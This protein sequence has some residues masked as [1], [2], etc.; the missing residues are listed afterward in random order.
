MH[1]TKLQET[2]N[3]RQIPFP[4]LQR[5]FRGIL[6]SSDSRLVIVAMPPY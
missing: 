4:K 2:S 1:P 6:N 3:E 5:I